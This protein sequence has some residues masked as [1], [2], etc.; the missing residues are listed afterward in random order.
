MNLILRKRI[1]QLIAISYA[2]KVDDVWKAYEKLENLEILLNLIET[3][4]LQDI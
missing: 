4:N 1:I 2:M 3:N